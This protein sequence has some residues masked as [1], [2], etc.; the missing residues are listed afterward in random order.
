MTR[1]EAPWCDHELDKADI[2]DH[3]QYPSWLRGQRR[4]SYVW[5]RTDRV[6]RV[7]NHETPGFSLVMD[8]A[9]R[10]ELLDH[11]LS[12]VINKLYRIP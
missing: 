12:N 11:L 10:E 9:S 3:E 6:M 5:L 4:V 8:K 2:S 7:L 1:T